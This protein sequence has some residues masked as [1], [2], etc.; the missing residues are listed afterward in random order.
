M[1][2]NKNS[3]PYEIL[4]FFNNNRK[5]HHPI[6]NW[7]K[8]ASNLSDIFENAFNAKSTKIKSGLIETLNL[9]DKKMAPSDAYKIVSAVATAIKHHIKTKI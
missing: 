1:L 5:C 3:V 8:N 4:D 7:H 6:N 2:C 9:L